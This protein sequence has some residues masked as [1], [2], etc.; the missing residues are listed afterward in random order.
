MRR[1]KGEERWIDLEELVYYGKG[2]KRS[3]KSGWLTRN[4]ARSVSQSIRESFKPPKT[5][6]LSKTYRSTSKLLET[7]QTGN[8]VRTAY[9]QMSVTEMPREL[10]LL[11]FPEK[12][13]RTVPQK[14]VNTIPQKVVPVIRDTVEDKNPT[15]ILE[16]FKILWLF[17]GDLWRGKH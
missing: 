9:V 6:K 12:A 14:A 2:K 11:S 8:S 16:L 17:F 1:P 4:I 5:P 10:Y 7:P 15:I 3:S 13:V